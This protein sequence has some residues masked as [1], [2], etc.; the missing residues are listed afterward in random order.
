MDYKKTTLLISLACLVGFAGDIGLQIIS[1]HLG[2]ED[3]WGLKDYFQQHGKVES[4]FIAMGMLTV[5]YIIYLLILRLP[6]TWYYIALYAVILD[7]LFRLT[8]CFPSLQGYYNHLN[9]FWSFFWAIIPMLLPFWIYKI[10]E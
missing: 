8:M 6:T 9:Y 10:L 7:L 3:H 4:V 2:G 1:P 5:F